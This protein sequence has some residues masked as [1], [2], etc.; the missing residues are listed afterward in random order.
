MGDAM[1]ER[2]NRAVQPE[3]HVYFLGDFA[4]GPGAT[5][6]YVFSVL[7]RLHGTVTIIL[8]NHDQP[9]KWGN[10]LK[11]FIEANKSLD[12]FVVLEDR[13]HEAKIDGKHFVM[14]HFPMEAWSGSDHGSIHLHGHTHTEF[15]DLNTPTKI[16]EYKDQLYR[17]KSYDIGVDMYGGPVQITGDLRYLNDPK[18]WA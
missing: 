4:M 6:D 17:T 1:I 12:R 3:D 10:G 14:C 2:W 18:G 8:G 9:S 7:A 5:D 15:S 13:I 16:R 11:A